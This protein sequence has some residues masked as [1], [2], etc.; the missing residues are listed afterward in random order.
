MANALPPV[1]ATKTINGTILPDTM[2]VPASQ[3]ELDELIALDAVR[4]PGEA[5]LALHE[6]MEANLAKAEAPAPK[7]AKPA[8]TEK[9]ATPAAPA[10][11][12][13]G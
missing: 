1:V 4:E 9:P 5:E 10:P 2:F 11:D 13:I 6:K 3:E 8:P 7:A 12:V